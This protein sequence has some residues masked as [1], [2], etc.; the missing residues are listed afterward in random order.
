MGTTSVIYG[1]TRSDYRA[2]D[3]YVPAADG[4]RRLRDGS[5]PAQDM[6]IFDVPDG[7]LL[8]LTK[9]SVAEALFVAT[10]APSGRLSEVAEATPTASDDR[11]K[12]YGR[13]AVW[14]AHNLLTARFMPAYAN[15]TEYTREASVG[16]T[17]TVEGQP[18]VA[19]QRVGWKEIA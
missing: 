11:I 1:M 8:G 13:L 12:A 5:M 10:N 2:S 16:D 6:L 15:T 4:W 3:N 9:E 14:F 19:C 18:S 17:V 7:L